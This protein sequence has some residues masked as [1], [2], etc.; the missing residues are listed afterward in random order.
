MVLCV[1]R[2]LS[3]RNSNRPTAMIAM[4]VPIENGRKYRSA[5]VAGGGVGSAVAAGASSTVK[6]ETACEA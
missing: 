6:A 1:Q 3:N 5:A 2:F 4:I